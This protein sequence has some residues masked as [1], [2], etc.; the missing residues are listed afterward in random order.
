MQ[1]L[2]GGISR[3]LGSSSDWWEPSTLVES[4]VRTADPAAPEWNS[5]SVAQVQ[6][7]AAETGIYDEKKHILF[8]WQMWKWVLGGS[9]E[10]ASL[11]VSALAR[12]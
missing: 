8:Y 7:T 3:R 6:A 2:Y 4:M 9:A 10:G 5:D 11:P 12:K 1:R